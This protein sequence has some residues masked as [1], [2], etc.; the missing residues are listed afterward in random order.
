LE[1]YKGPL[2]S[3]ER[4]I[5]TFVFL[6]LKYCQR[7]VVVVTDAS[8]VDIVVELLILFC[9]SNQHVSTLK[10]VE[11]T[12]I[13]YMSEAFGHATL[14][15]YSSSLLI[16]WPNDNDILLKQL[17]PY[18]TCIH[19]L[20]MIESLTKTIMCLNAPVIPSLKQNGNLYQSIILW[21]AD[22]ESVFHEMS[23]QWTCIVDI[24]LSTTNWLYISR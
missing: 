4:T 1:L 11:S 22:G 12:T 2:R 20:C 7:W 23:R 24:I 10:R 15:I 17:M 6:I 8:L 13:T 18:V 5:S 16:E 19:T 3:K 21:Y 9:L 14:S